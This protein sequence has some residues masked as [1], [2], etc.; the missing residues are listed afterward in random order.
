[1][2]LVAA[3]SDLRSIWG[4]LA[5]VGSTEDSITVAMPAWYVPDV[6]RFVHP[7]GRWFCEWG[8]K[9]VVEATS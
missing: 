3:F 8:V 1:M 6:E 5:L 9:V 7:D 4:T 2:D